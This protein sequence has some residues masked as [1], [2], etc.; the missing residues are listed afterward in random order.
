MALLQ[1]SHIPQALSGSCSPFP[2]LLGSATGLPEALVHPVEEPASRLM[3]AAQRTPPR[4]P[5]EDLPVAASIART[6]ISH[7]IAISRPRCNLD[8]PHAPPSLLGLATP[9]ACVYCGESTPVF[10]SRWPQPATMAC[11]GCQA[12]LRFCITC[13]ERDD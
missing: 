9:S 3:P 1:G 6:D 8:M 7:L 2:H 5:L 13:Q 10:R 12:R 4:Q 11:N